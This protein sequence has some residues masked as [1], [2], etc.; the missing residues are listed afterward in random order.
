MT[1]DDSMSPSVRLALDKMWPAV[2]E[3]ARKHFAVIEEFLLSG[4][5]STTA[6]HLAASRS[7]HR[8]SGS[9]GMFG[10]HDASSV[11]AAIEALLA[12]DSSTTQTELRTLVDRLDGLLGTTTQ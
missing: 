8:L 7:A 2:Y 5:A 12:T 4:T 9:L 10:R 11:A 3:A 6:Q 1:R